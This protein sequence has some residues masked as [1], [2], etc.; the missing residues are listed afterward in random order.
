MNYHDYA[1]K[2]ERGSYV[3]RRR[4]LD[5]ETIYR[6]DFREC[7]DRA[8]DAHSVVV[9]FTAFDRL[10]SFEDTLYEIQKTHRVYFRNNQKPRLYT[11]ITDKKSLRL[12]SP[13]R[14]PTVLF[15]LPKDIPISEVQ[16]LVERE[17]PDNYECPE[18]SRPTQTLSSTIRALIRLERV[19]KSVAGWSS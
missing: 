16:S 6:P 5:E 7:C 14:Y 11:Q 19:R 8:S 9:V 4:N 12:C 13:G 2:R 18:D 1:E 10:M 15:A 3:P 17:F